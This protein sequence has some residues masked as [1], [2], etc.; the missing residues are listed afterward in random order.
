MSGFKVNGVDLDDIFMK[1][2]PSN[3]WNNQIPSITTNYRTS[4][5]SDL[6]ERYIKKGSYPNDA[7]ASATNMLVKYAGD[8][9]DLNTLFAAKYEW[10]NYSITARGSCGGGLESGSNDHAGNNPDQ[11][12]MVGAHITCTMS[13][14][15]KYNGSLVNYKLYSCVGGAA[16]G[17]DGDGNRLGYPGGS[18][19]ALLNADTEE[20]IIV[21]GAGGGSGGGNGNPGGAAFHFNMNMSHKHMPTQGQTKYLYVAYQNETLNGYMAPYW[22][23][24][25]VNDDDNIMKG[26]QEITN[27]G[28]DYKDRN[29]IKTYGGGVY[30]GLNAKN[31][32][33]RGGGGGRANDGGESQNGTKGS[34]WNGGKGAKGDGQRRSAGGG[35]GGA[36]W[37]GGGGGNNHNTRNGREGSPG[38]GGGST[39]INP[40]YNPT[41]LDITAG[42]TNYY[43]Y[44]K[45]GNT[46][47]G[48]NDG[49][50][51][52]NYDTNFTL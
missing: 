46:T 34:K 6:K 45:I 24:N 50:F 21:P 3:P 17:S 52:G 41:N 32:Y 14:I 4:D 36:G 25:K 5:G 39:Y 44:I 40:F 49:S 26:T 37:Y 12:S 33:S 8:F 10:D 28:G 35:G 42:G 29:E 51:I 22:D 13:L 30:H 7:T 23:S 11:Y 48:Y 20:C 1:K 27:N 38:G 9:V 47:H 15:K 43:R 18:T 31:H 19:Y 2:D 16:G